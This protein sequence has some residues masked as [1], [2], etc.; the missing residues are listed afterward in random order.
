[1][2]LMSH[3]QQ[4]IIHLCEKTF[5]KWI[6]YIRDR[7]A[8]HKL[9]WIDHRLLRRQIWPRDRSETEYILTELV[10]RGWVVGWGGRMK[11]LSK[12][13]NE[14]NLTCAKYILIIKSLYDYL[15]SFYLMKFVTQELMLHFALHSLI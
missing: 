11:I 14:K 3:L 6:R 15:H 4:G 8:A 12:N 7:S 10:E 1:M 5:M 13:W 9:Q 2:S